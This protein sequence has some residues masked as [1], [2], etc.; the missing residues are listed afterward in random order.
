MK[1]IK[2]PT[3]LTLFRLFLVPV[4]VVVFYLPFGWAHVVT[5]AIFALAGLTDWLDGYLA[6]KWHQETEFGA[7][8]DPVVDKI[9]VAFALVLLV[10]E[11]NLFFIAI[12]AAIIICREIVV[13]A[14]REWMS[15]I[16]ERASVAV[17]YIGK[18]KTAIQMIAIIVLLAINPLSYGFFFF[19]GYILLYFAAL[20]TLWSMCMYLKTAWPN[21]KLG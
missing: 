13:S 4:F 19:S 6:R 7:F 18:V 15:K 1:A 8:L 21:F 20:L 2:I 14:L 9:M 17:N 16:G 12:P 5:A 11:P 3:L 10:S